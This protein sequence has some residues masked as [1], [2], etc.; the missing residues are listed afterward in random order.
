MNDRHYDSHQHGP[1][2][3]DAAPN[4]LSR[5]LALV[6]RHRAHQFDLAV[7]EEGFVALDP[8]LE[9]IRSQSGLDGVTREDLELLTRE[10]DRKRYEIRDDSM[11][12]T[13]GHSFRR[14]IRYPAVEPPEH[15][16]VGVASAQVQEVRL[17]GLHPEGRQYLHLS[18]KE[19]EAREVGSRHSADA[20][21][22]T[23]LALEASQSGIPFH[24][25]TDGLYL[26]LQLPA[27][28]L[29]LQVQYGRSPKKGRRR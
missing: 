5:F 17:H 1:S 13:Y 7:D 25:P 14:P 15:L 18:E 27:R 12:A 20:T 21:V 9:V 29:D 16:Y 22:V 6:L 8:L 23:V 19:D 26:A 10:G 28:F 11:R 3:G 4:R 2:S 24:R